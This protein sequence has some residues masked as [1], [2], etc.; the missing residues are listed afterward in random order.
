MT[1]TIK[2]G[3]V[4]TVDFPGVTGIKRRPAIVVSTQTYQST[5]PD[6]IV[7]LL[8]SQTSGETQPSDYLLLDWK[9]A[10]LRKLSLFRTFLAT[11]PASSVTVVGQLSARDWQAIQRCLRTAL[12]T[13]APASG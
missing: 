8:T 13:C 5:R 3:A 1:T 11:L 9:E 10:G 4:V 6:I 12:D 2:A 7:G